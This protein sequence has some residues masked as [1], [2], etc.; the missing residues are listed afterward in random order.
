MSGTLN[1]SQIGSIKS[2]SKPPSETGRQS[3]AAGD[4]SVSSDYYGTG[5]TINDG[6]SMHER[7][8]MRFF[9]KVFQPDA[10]LFQRMGSIWE[11]EAQL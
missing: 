10:P 7:L 8:N 3:V 1:Q 9:S 6:G 4:P 5:N 11:L 2:P